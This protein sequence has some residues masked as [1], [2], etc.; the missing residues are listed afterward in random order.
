MPIEVGCQPGGDLSDGARVQ[1]M[2][3]AHFDR[4]SAGD[5]ILERIFCREH[6]ACP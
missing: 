5:Q 6:A 4:G 3:G 2:R 1:K